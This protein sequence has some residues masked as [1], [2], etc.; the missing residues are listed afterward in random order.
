MN[1][2]CWEC[3][4]CGETTCLSLKRKWNM[5]CWWPRGCLVVW[6]VGDDTALLGVR[7][8][9]DGNVRGVEGVECSKRGEGQAAGAVLEAAGVSDCMGD[10]G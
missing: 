4:N 9:R 3:G 6:E 8:M 2:A 5:S 10:G 1:K 7:D